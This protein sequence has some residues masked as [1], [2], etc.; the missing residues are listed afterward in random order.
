[1]FVYAFADREADMWPSPCYGVREM[2]LAN[3]YLFRVSGADATKI[4]VAASEFETRPEKD[5]NSVRVYGNPFGLSP[6]PGTLGAVM[7][8]ARFRPGHPRAPER[9]WERTVTIESNLLGSP[10]LAAVFAGTVLM[11][12][13]ADI[14]KLPAW[15]LP[16]GDAWIQPA[17]VIIA[18]NVGQ[19]GLEEIYFTATQIQHQYEQNSEGASWSTKAL[20]QS[21]TQA[22]V[23]AITGLTP[24]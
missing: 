16:R 24:G 5:Y 20:L 13:D 8:R 1:M 23:S 4:L 10:A 17:D 7:G 15:N 19:L 3:A 18:E 11:G 9:T 14:A 6:M 21:M 22:E 2:I 12:L